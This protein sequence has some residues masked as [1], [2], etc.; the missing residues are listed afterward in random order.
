MSPLAF[1]LIAFLHLLG[2]VL[3][4]PAVLARGVFLRRGLDDARA[5]RAALLLD[6]WWGL[7]ALI[8]FP[9]GLYRVFTLGKGVA[10]YLNNPFF[11]AKMTL[12]GVVFALEVWPM[13]ELI[14]ERIVERKGHTILT[15]TKVRAIAG[16]SFAQSALLIVVLFCAAMMARGVGQR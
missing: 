7:S 9:S 12:F 8:V 2:V 4:I 11:I 6:G 10:F 14:R 3:A 13:I 5:K 1:A 15:P 16:I